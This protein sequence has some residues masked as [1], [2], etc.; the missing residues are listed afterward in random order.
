MDI[1]NSDVA[2]GTADVSTLTF[3]PANWNVA[4]SVTVTGIDDN[5]VQTDTNIVTVSPNASSAVEYGVLA[6][7][8]VTASYTDDD[9]A[10]VVVDPSGISG[11]PLTLPE[12]GGVGTI[13]VVL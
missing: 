6:A 12:N 9:V 5:Y 13:Q 4:Q 10:T 3:T 2:Q 11:M 1:S 8:T 7:Q